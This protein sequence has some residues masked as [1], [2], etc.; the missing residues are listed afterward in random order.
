METTEPVGDVASLFV[1][2]EF[3]QLVQNELRGDEEARRRIDRPELLQFWE[4]ELVR[5]NQELDVQIAERHA[6][7]NEYQQQCRSQSDEQAK[8]DYLRMEA[9][10]NK[11]RAS[12]LRFKL[13]VVTRLRLVRAKKRDD[14]AKQ[15]ARLESRV[16]ALENQ[17]QEMKARLDSA[18]V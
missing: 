6:R 3:A 1:P 8:E 5:L 14:L 18:A 10:Y 2:G 17:L 16:A 11:W 4:N 13:C 15:E 9:S 12:V 7:L